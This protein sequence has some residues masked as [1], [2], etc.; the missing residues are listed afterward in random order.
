V[1]SPRRSPRCPG[2]RPNSN[3]VEV[4]FEAGIGFDDGILDFEEVDGAEV[5]YETTDG[6]RTVNCFSLV[7][8]SKKLVIGLI[9]TFDSE[10]SLPE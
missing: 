10:N 4:C 3:I 8:Y 2:K 1:I 5:I 9:A 7:L 6:G